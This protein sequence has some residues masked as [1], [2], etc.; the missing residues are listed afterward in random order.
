MSCYFRHLKDILEEA[1]IEVTPA[2]KKRIDQAIHQIA[3]VNYKDCPET[4]RRLKQEITV[5]LAK[6]QALIS[7]LK[8][9]S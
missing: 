2:N 1:G 8:S 4:W 5:D 9:Y 3:G 7:Q 6:R